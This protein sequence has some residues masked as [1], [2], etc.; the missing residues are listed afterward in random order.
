MPRVAGGKGCAPEDAP[1]MARAYASRGLLGRIG[2][3][4]L[5]VELERKR[6]MAISMHAHKRS[7]ELERELRLL[8]DEQRI[9]ASTEIVVRQELEKMRAQERLVSDKKQNASQL[10]FFG[11]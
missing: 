10:D 5:E 2:Q 11:L 3:V 4:R 9:R 7:K 8:D 6:L 1:M